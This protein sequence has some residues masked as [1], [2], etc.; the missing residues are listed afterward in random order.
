M[1][2]SDEQ[3]PAKRPRRAGGFRNVLGHCVGSGGR[4]SVGHQVWRPT[5][6]HLAR[7]IRAAAGGLSPRRRPAFAFLLFPRAAL[8]IS[9]RRSD[10]CFCARAALKASRATWFSGATPCGGP[11]KGR[12]AE[13]SRADPRCH[14]LWTRCRLS[15][16]ALS[17]WRDR[18][19]LLPLSTGCL[20]S[21]AA[22]WLECGSG[23]ADAVSPSAVARAVRRRRYRTLTRR[24]CSIRKS[25]AGQLDDV[26]DDEVACLARHC[27]QGFFR[28]RRC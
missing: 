1:T 10:E 5:H 4:C 26:V 12:G 16:T 9:W 21:A 7:R 14:R 24:R 8:G 17:T 22:S 3:S 25:N 27:R 15:E 19:G 18:S 6:G 11:L 2:S 28:G 23:C 20:R 13:G